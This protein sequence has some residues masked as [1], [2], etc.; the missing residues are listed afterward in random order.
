MKT[1]ELSDSGISLAL[2]TATRRLGRIG[3]ATL[4]AS[5]AM[6]A[7]AGEVPSTAEVVRASC[8]FIEEMPSSD[9]DY[10]D[11][12]WREINKSHVIQITSAAAGTPVLPSDAN[13]VAESLL[14]NAGAQLP[15]TFPAA[16]LQSVKDALQSLERDVVGQNAGALMAF[17]AAGQPIKRSIVDASPSIFL[18][19]AI[20]VRCKTK[21]AAADTTGV[22][23]SN[24]PATTP[25]KGKLFA[26]K[27]LRLRG[28]VDGLTATDKD[29]KK[30]TKV[31]AAK[32]GLK[33]VRTFQ[34]DE[35]RKE[36]QTVSIKGVLGYPIIGTNKSD[37]LEQSGLISF[38]SYELTQNRVDPPPQLDPPKTERDGDTEILKFGL[39][40]H[41]YFPMFDDRAGLETSLTGAYLFDRV[42]KSERLQ[43]TV[44][45][46]PYID[47]IGI[48]DVGDYR[49]VGDSKVWTR[50]GVS[51]VTNYNIL[52]KTGSLEDISKETFG[53]AGGKIGFE[54]SF[55]KN[56]GKGVFVNAKYSALR[57][58]RGDPAA[59]PHIERKELALGHRWWADGKVGFEASLQLIDGE[60]LDSFV[61]E[62]E[63]GVAFGLIF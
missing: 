63:L 54:M 12:K 51:L 9:I 56:P 7:V 31:D 40:G 61:D 26:L 62:N 16:R 52:T 8:A 27:N 6:P 28:T 50:C 23:Q 34:D 11:K 55:G 2:S 57:R 43:S 3:I 44:T 42:K 24:T 39:I 19:P 47:D 48:C 45:F 46:S 49:Q 10:K 25:A 14:G 59:V 15:A 30:D 36:T 60:N 41:H 5:S 32:L 22:A 29:L 21:L 18:D 58:Y 37:K 33:R 1:S 13:A 38:V 17:D 4:L 53:H 35:S 20:A